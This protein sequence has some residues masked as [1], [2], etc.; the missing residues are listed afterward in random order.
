[1]V[2]VTPAAMPLLSLPSVMMT[3]PRMRTINPIER[4]VARA[5]RLADWLD[6]RYL[7]PIVGLILP[8]GGD[9]ALAI[10][11]LFPVYVA[12]RHRMPAIIVA[13]MIRNL[14]IDLVV[15]AIPLVGDVFDFVYKAHRKNADL[16]V[17]RYVLGPSPARDWA[18]VLG[19]LVTLL[20]ALVLPV[21]A[22]VLWLA[23]WR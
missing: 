6:D 22:L 2:D 4:D 5:V 23:P 13:R 15:G 16:L 17:E 18:A 20:A 19:A 8:V 21:V 9:I 14:V 3:S 10:V 1:M 12:L 11:G 7:D